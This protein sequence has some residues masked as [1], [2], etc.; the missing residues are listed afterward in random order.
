MTS[1]W[2]TNQKTNGKL[3]VRLNVGEYEQIEGKH[4][5]KYDLAAPITNATSVQIALVVIAMNAAWIAEV[6]DVD[7]AFLQS[8][9]T[10][11]EVLYMGI[12]IGFEQ[13]YGDNEILMMNVPIYGTKQAAHCFYKVLEDKMKARNWNQSKAD[14]CLHYLW[15]NGR[16]SVML[17]WVNNILALRHP[18]DVK[19]IKDDLK[20]AFECTCEGALT[21]Y[22]GSRID[23]KRKSNRF[24]DVKFTQPVLMQKLK[25]EHLESMEGKAHKIPALAGQIMVKGDGSGTMEDREAT[26]YRSGT[27][28]CM[29]TVQ[30]SR[31]DI[32]NVTRGQARQIS[33]PIMIPI[34]QNI[35]QSMLLGGDGGGSEK[36]GLNKV[37]FMRVLLGGGIYSMLALLWILI[38]DFYMILCSR[39]IIYLNNCSVIRLSFD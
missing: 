5:F 11:G 23:I 3:R 22:V 16:L 15:M 37:R 33:A 21:D 12:P 24:A 6:I 35:S 20:S 2:A 13:Y 38:F 8:K 27:T 39:Q 26:V 32:Y 18:E 30:W 25:D 1:T 19:Q 29:Y 31:L 7:G 10:N 28:N 34:P 14:P 4:Y 17:S 9:F 36:K